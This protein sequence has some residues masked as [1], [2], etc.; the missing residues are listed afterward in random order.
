MG[1]PGEGGK[2]FILTA[3]GSHGLAGPRIGTSA[4]LLVPRK[5]GGSQTQPFKE[6][7]GRGAYGGVSDTQELE[8][9]TAPK[10]PC[11]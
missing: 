6:A 1:C 4:A 9:H 11:H 3:W 10:V 5:V 2:I 7:R 8:G